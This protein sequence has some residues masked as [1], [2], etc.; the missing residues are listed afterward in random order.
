MPTFLVDHDSNGF[1]VCVT[2]VLE[3]HTFYAL[4]YLPFVIDYRNR[5]KAMLTV[6]LSIRLPGASIPNL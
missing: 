5:E 1:F 2:V 4:S 6:K 3:L